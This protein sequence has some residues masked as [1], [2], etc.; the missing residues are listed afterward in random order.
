M[1]ALVLCAALP[2]P[3][4]AAVIRVPT[5]QPTIQAAINAAVAG[6]TVLVAPGTY[7]ENINFLGKAIT[8]KS[9]QGPEVTIID[10][11]RSGPVA[12]FASGEGRES[13]LSGF[14]LTNGVA[15]AG[16]PSF[17]D[18]GGVFIGGS[19]PTITGNIITRNFACNG[20]GIAISGGSPLI[21]GNTISRNERTGCSGGLGGMGVLSLNGNEVQILGNVISDNH[22]GP[23]GGGIYMG[24]TGTIKGNIITGNS[25]SGEFPCGTGG[26]GIFLYAGMTLLAQNL[27]VGNQAPCGGGI[28]WH[29]GLDILFLNNTVAGNQSPQGSAIFGNRGSNWKRLINNI[30]VAGP[31]ET[32]VFCEGFDPV[33]QPQFRFNNVFSPSGTAYGG[34][35]T[36]QTGANG[37]I[38][39]DP[40][41]LDPSVGDYRVG[42]GSPV[43]DAGDSSVPELPNEDLLGHG[44]IVDGDGDGQAVI[45]VG[46]SLVSNC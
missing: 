6:D 38:S 11:S 7:T 25:A 5:D 32:T 12:M 44:R 19:S 20:A 1:I 18:G 10:G 3:A 17:D 9:E 27:I 22:G 31:G 13:V 21:Q 35:C 43:V 24:A 4:R 15:A 33:D 2:Y 34:N 28:S 41:F 23:A 40:L 46:A 39:A 29:Y 42:L 37:N 30:L 36:D 16:F 14:T 26:G 8:V 45:D